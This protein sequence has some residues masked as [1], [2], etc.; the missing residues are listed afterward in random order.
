MDRAMPDLYFRGMTFLLGLR[1]LVRPREGVL[2]EVDIRPGFRVLDYGCG[3]GGYVPATS[4]R[5]GETGRVYALDLHPLAMRLVD[6]LCEKEGLSNVETILSDC[7]TG[8]AD[9]SLDVVL[10]YDV[11]HLLNDPRA[12]L[13]E[14]HR[15]LKAGGILSFQN[16]HMHEEDILNGV[17]GSRLFRLVGR[18]TH[19]YTF[20]PVRVREQPC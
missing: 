7:H 18:G 12:V 11:F 9:G 20:S 15:V 5:V 17:V 2:E 13:A 10:L 3:P 14:L 1:D 19:T 4:R 8:L 16:P 6:R